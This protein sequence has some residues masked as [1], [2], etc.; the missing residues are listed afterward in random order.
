MQDAFLTLPRQKRKKKL[1]RTIYLKAT[2]Q[3]LERIT[4]IHYFEI[5]AFL[6]FLNCIVT[7]HIIKIFL[8]PNSLILFDIII[9]HE[10]LLLR[11]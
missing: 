7:V 5:L 2:L 1:S 8:L 4:F 11:I 10:P 3:P 6:Y 9:R